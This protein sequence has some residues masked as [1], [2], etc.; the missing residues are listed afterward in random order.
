MEIL[1]P[2]LA[3][4]PI[5]ALLILALTRDDDPDERSWLLTLLIPALFLR[6]GLALLF[7]AVPEIRYFHEDAV[8]YEIRGQMLA[9]VWRGEAPAFAMGDNNVG[10]FYVC[11]AIYYVFGRYQ[12]NP[13]CF[14]AVLGTILALMIYRLAKRLFHVLVARRA[15]LLVALMPSMVLWGSTAIKDVPVTFAIVVSLSSIV[16]LRKNIT[17]INL[18]GVIVPILAIQ[19]MRF[20]I[21][22]FVLFAIAVA[23]VIDRGARA[24]T[25]AY[26]QVV[27]IGAFGGL[28]LI[29]GFADR[30]S[31]DASRYFS[32]EYVSNYRHGMAVTAQSGFDHDVDISNPGSALAYLPFGLAHLLFAPFPWQMVSLRPIIAA[33]ETILWWTMFPATV[34]GIAFAFRK[35]F[36]E[37]ASLMVFSVS[38]A[39]VYSLVHGNVGSAFRQRAQILVFL[40]IFSAL[41]AYVNKARQMGVDPNQLVR[42]D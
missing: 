36:E 34:R 8:G 39:C 2:L 31:D 25:G 41:G 24:F 5:G 16:A 23:L 13:S 42:R 27:L 40:F 7:V 17:L 32:L 11:G 3:F 38:L 37:T 30:A 4:G 26:R 21:V 1:V 15:A 12:A 14:N 19:A 33:P 35:R 6:L 10:F 22:Y 29:L 18:V 9:S 28:L 20:Y